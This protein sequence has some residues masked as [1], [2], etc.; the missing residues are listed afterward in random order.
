MLQSPS[1]RVAYLVPSSTSKEGEYYKVMQN[2][3][4]C[5]DYGRRVKKGNYDDCTDEGCKHIVAVMVAD[6]IEKLAGVE[7]L[8]RRVVTENEEEW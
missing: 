1:G 6:V 4:T 7:G 8:V 2:Y 3:C 5:H